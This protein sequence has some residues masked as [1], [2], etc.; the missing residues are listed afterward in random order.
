M[1]Y[2]SGGRFVEFLVGFGVIY[3]FVLLCFILFSETTH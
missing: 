2:E 1:F 3:I